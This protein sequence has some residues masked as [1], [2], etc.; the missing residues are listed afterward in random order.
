M[1]AIHTT[2]YFATNASPETMQKQC[3]ALMDVLLEREQ[4]DG[5]V[6]DSTV[7]MSGDIGVVEVEAFAAADDRDKAEKLIAE[8]ILGAV[9]SVVG[10]S[11]AVETERRVELVSA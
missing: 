11:D 5:T 2:Y 4:L 10:L 6:T 1:Q 8:H 9:R 3:L 7:S